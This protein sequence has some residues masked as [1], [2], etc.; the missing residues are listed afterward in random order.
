MLRNIN[1][2]GPYDS[3]SELFKLRESFT[4]ENCISLPGFDIEKSDIQKYAN[5]A[6]GLL[7]DEHFRRS[8]QDSQ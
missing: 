1:T 6:K 7:F 2:G 4:S 8:Q 3:P 5:H